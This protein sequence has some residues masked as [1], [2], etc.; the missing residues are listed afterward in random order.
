MHVDLHLS[1]PAAGERDALLG[2]LGSRLPLKERKGPA[3]PIDPAA[4]V[5][6][7]GRGVADA[8]RAP[9]EGWDEPLR[10]H[11]EAGGRV[12]LSGFACV[13]AGR[14]GGAQPRSASVPEPSGSLLGVAAMPG[15]PLFH[16]TP[17][18]VDLLHAAGDGAGEVFGWDPASLPSDA[19]ALA[20]LRRAGSV[21]AAEFD[22]ECPVLVEFRVGAGRLIALG[23]EI[24]F[25]DLDPFLAERRARFL[26]DLFDYLQSDTAAEQA[27]GWLAPGIGQGTAWRAGGRDSA[28]I[29]ALPE[30]APA[31]EDPL[32]R[33]LELDPECEAGALPRFVL[34]ARDGQIAHVRADGVIESVWCRGF[35]AARDVAL[36]FESQGIEAVRPVR[37]AVHP[38][39]LRFELSTGGSVWLR[40][41]SEGGGFTLSVEAADAAL[42]VSLE[43]ALDLEPAWPY[44]TGA[45]GVRVGSSARHG[46]ALT[47]SGERFDVLAGVIADARPTRAWSHDD[48]DALAFGRSFTVPPGDALTVT[49]G[50]RGEFGSANDASADDPEPCA[51]L[52]ITTGDPAVDRAVTLLAARLDDF[53]SPDPEGGA[54]R[55]VL[56][57][58]AAAGT[59]TYERVRRSL[60][61]GS[62][63][64]AFGDRERFAGILRRSAGSA[65]ADG[66]IAS[67]AALAGRAV[68]HRCQ[69]S[70][71]AFLDAVGQ[72][73]AWTG[74]LELVRE[75]WPTIR[76]AAEWMERFDDDRAA[77]GVH[78]TALR[79]RA[80][81]AVVECAERLGEDGVTTRAWRQVEALRTALR[82]RYWIVD[83]GS[84]ALA[85]SPGVDGAPGTREEASSVSC[86]VPWAL[87]LGE[88][89][90]E[91]AALRRFSTA[92][93]QTDWGVRTWPADDPR[94]DP[95]KAGM[96]TPDTT[97]TAAL[98]DFLNGRPDSAWP[99]VRAL[100]ATVEDFAPGQGA[101]PL[102]GER[103]ERLE[104]AVDTDLAT[105]DALAAML[106]RGLLGFRVLAEEPRVVFEPTLPGALDRLAFEGIALGD[107]RLSGSV[108]R[109]AEGAGLEVRISVE[110]EPT[111]LAIAPFVPGPAQCRS[112]ILDGDALDPVLEDV[113]DG[114]RVRVQAELSPGDHVLTFDVVPDVLVGFA[115]ETAQVGA[116]SA[117]PRYL[118]RRVLDDGAVA[119]DFELRDACEVSLRT[120]GRTVTAIE[121]AE[122]IGGQALRVTPGPGA[123]YRR[124][125]VR[126]HLG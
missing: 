81:S 74:D 19:V 49:L 50:G 1:S 31:E 3:D 44:S 84:Y 105:T 71:P 65:D 107:S 30:E 47:L 117:G 25:A 87:G 12:L 42:A 97:A 85:L 37:V 38:R 125:T 83:D 13:L 17:G 114:V 67:R 8:S 121:G 94:Y 100:A 112:V 52:G 113:G 4:T 11:L 22:A 98:A 57:R 73:L 115:P 53:T 59:V 102:H 77:R 24:D 110:G 33:T 20:V 78:S 43:G 90:S 109:G 92:G 72:W 126:V 63:L 23:L 36:F 106:L 123:G 118:G 66:R 69:D 28:P 119:L 104:P 15:E 39:A 18:G 80:W 5:W 41:P 26:G 96:L 34:A 55:F 6:V 10:A 58:A 86:A 75:L 124:A 101:G 70:T 82:E 120:P 32:W 103:Y 111:T 14:I 122:R 62:S 56:H 99:R 21:D 91:G 93:F 61:M 89:G 88:H 48:G 45:F 29:V 95:G 108:A 2:L 7:H 79:L 40:R 76:A 35:R 51:P 54:P 9:W 116:E 16:R 64:L 60:A 27:I 46:A 68:I